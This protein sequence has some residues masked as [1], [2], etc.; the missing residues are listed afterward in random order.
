[1]FFR[2]FF[3][4]LPS[5]LSRRSE[6]LVDVGNARFWIRGQLKAYVDAL[7]ILN[8]VWNRADY[9]PSFSV[10]PVRTV[11][12]VGAYIG[13]F[14]VWACKRFHPKR[15]VA[16][17][18]SDMYDL[19]DKNVRLNGCAGEGVILL[20]QALHSRSVP[21][22]VG[23]FMPALHFTE[24]NSGGT[25]EG[26]TL[27]QIVQH[28]EP[29]PIDFLKMDI[30]GGERFILTEQN[31]SLFRERVRYAAVEAHDL[32]GNHKEQAVEYFGR[33]GF[34]VRYRQIPWFFGIYRIEALNPALGSI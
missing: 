4:C 29:E 32:H 8:E 20:R 26:V 14:T 24:E 12:D 11:L 2:L 9:E 28:Y 5:L 23:G 21:L 7:F 25:V 22:R 33:L 6:I 10:E 34:Q 15:I 16:L 18:P 17:E 31:E 1:M 19:L 27:S 30:E 13:D 3:R